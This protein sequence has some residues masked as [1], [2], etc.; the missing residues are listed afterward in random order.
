MFAEKF[1]LFNLQHRTAKLPQTFGLI[2]F[3]NSE[4]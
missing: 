1:D 3:I 2:Y 4:L